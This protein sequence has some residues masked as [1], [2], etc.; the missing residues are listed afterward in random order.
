MAGNGVCTQRERE[1]DE[2]E[3][4]SASKFGG[5]GYPSADGSGVPTLAP[6][7]GYLARTWRRIA[8]DSILSRTVGYLLFDIASE[9]VRFFCGRWV[10][11]R[12]RID[13][14]NLSD[15]PV[16]FFYVGVNDFDSEIISIR[17]R[18]T[19][20]HEKR[21]TMMLLVNARQMWTMHKGRIVIVFLNLCCIV[22]REPILSL[23]NWLLTF[24]SKQLVCVVHNIGKAFLPILT[25]TFR[26]KVVSR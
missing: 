13:M 19:H 9:P 5:R 15:P 10:P 3:W 17:S 11:K 7:L 24:T 26:F 1:R 6:I 20:S 18:F 25:T 16:S 12:Q 8:K 21:G 23:W 14:R 2:N 22:C 4:P